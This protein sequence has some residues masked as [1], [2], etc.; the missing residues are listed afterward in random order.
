MTRNLKIFTGLVVLGTAAYL[1]LGD[2]INHLPQ[3]AQTIL[4]FVMLILFFYIVFNFVFRVIYRLTGVTD[5][6]MFKGRMH[7]W[8]RPTHQQA[9]EINRYWLV[10][11]GGSLLTYIAYTLIFHNLEWKNAL[12]FCVIVIVIVTLAR[13][14][15]KQKIAGHTKE[16]IFK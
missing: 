14:N 16:E 3:T 5:T 9:A 2:L 6:L 12:I 10:W 7:G 15:S 8:P 4:G 13:L 11:L 1:A